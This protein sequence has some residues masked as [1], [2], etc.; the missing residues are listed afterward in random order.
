VMEKIVEHVFARGS[1]PNWIAWRQ[2]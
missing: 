1:L 2:P